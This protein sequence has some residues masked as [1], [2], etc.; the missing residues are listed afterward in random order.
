MNIDS[1]AEQ[2]LVIEIDTLIGNLGVENDLW[3]IENSSVSYN[4]Y[5][6]NFP[7]SLETDDV[8]NSIKLRMDVVG[9]GPNFLYDV[10][11]DLLDPYWH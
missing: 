5:N 4:D 6:L 10:N 3:C 2:Y 1:S 7:L 9:N 8:V 11:Y